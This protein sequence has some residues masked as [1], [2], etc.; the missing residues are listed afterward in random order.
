MELTDRASRALR[1][2]G[3]AV[4]PGR[5]LALRGPRRHLG[6][7]PSPQRRRRATRCSTGWVR[8]T[9]R[10][11]TSAARRCSASWPASSTASTTPSPTSVAPPRHRAELGFLQTE[12]YQ[13][14]SL[15]RAQCQAG[16]YD[17]RRRHPGARHRQGRSHRRRA[18]G[19]PRPGPPRARPPG[20]RRPTPSARAAL[21][22][23]A[24]WHRAAG[25]G[26]QAA[27][28]EC[29]LAAM[30]AA[31]QVPD[32]GPR[33]AAIL[34][35]AR[36]DGDAHVEVFALDAL[37]RLAAEAGDVDH[38]P[39]ALRRGRPAHGR[40]RRLH[41]RPR[42]NRRARAS[43]PSSDPAQRVPA[44]RSRLVG[45][46]VRTRSARWFITMNAGNPPA[47]IAM[48]TTCPPRT[49]SPSSRNDHTH[50]QRGLHDL[51]DRDRA[52]RDRLLREHQ[53]PVRGDPGEQREDRACRSSPCRSARTRRRW[54]S[55]GGARRPR[56]SGRSSP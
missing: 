56:R 42:P 41:H 40:R 55:P 7:R 26:E 31:D 37:G 38:G 10:G 4:G 16:D 45:A 33:L 17:S 35:E 48:P 51:R 43:D 36:R 14:S 5:E 19:G 11:S 47:A 22:S 9:I 15:G 46:P 49:V 13:T 44:S 34:D 6:R 29:L 8:S 54:R 25:G 30:D 27:L 20:P 18:P 2:A 21:E 23:A 3:P 24:A 1:R 32:A 28:G 52:D 53:Q 50:R 39:G 12:A